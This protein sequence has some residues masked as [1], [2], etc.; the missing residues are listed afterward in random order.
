MKILEGKKYFILCY[1][2]GFFI[3]I[4]YANLLSGDYMAGIGILDDY[5]LEQYVQTEIN[6]AEFLWYVAYLRLLPAVFLFTFGCTKLRKGFKRSDSGISCHEAG[7]EGNRTV[8][9]VPDAAVYLLYGG[10][11]DASV[12]SVRLS[13]S[14]VES[15]KN[16]M[17]FFVY[18]DR[19]SFGMLCKSSNRKNVSAYNI[20]D[21]RSMRCGVI[22]GIMEQNTFWANSI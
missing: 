2:T 18:A 15:F 20:N 7:N 21:V 5:F 1:M 13:G 11:F 8:S 19:D 16:R 14:A 12:V 17:L 3:G 6:T 9:L 22:R 4:L 10:I